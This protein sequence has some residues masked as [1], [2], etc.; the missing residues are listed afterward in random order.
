VRDVV[1]PL[2]RRKRLIL[3]SFLGVF[4][5]LVAAVLAAGAKYES[6]V[7]ILVSRERQDP[8]VTSQA[9]GQLMGSV[10]PLTDEEVNS[11][12]ELLVSSDV[13]QKVVLANGMEKSQG[14]SVMDLFHPGETDQDRAARAVRGLARKLKVETPTKTNL[15]EVTYSAGNP[16]RAYGVLKSL[17]VQRCT[18]RKAHMTS[19][20]ER[21]TATRLR[22]KRPRPSFVS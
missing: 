1:A 6:H 4:A 14:K 22:W 5:L 13:L 12:A 16:N 19:S 10:T 7:S 8:L 17:S 15:I 18:V 21:R 9:T 2:F 20:R 11:E 3:F